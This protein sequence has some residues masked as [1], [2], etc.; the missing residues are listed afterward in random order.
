MT[1]SGVS[2]ARR[3]VL[4]SECA[5]FGSA[6]SRKIKLRLWNR[7]GLFGSG[8]MRLFPFATVGT[9]VA[10][11]R[12]SILEFCSCGRITHTES[13]LKVLLYGFIAPPC[14]LH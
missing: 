11:W 3:G 1:V 9:E 6:G 12:H 14:R 10:R 4:R 8:V 7:V 13:D 2:G 5:K